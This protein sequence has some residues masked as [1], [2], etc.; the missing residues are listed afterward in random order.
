VTEVIRQ[1]WPEA[2]ITGVDSS[3]AMLARAR[4]ADSTVDWRLGD[5]LEWRPDE[6]VDLV[7]SNAALHWLDGD[8]AL[9]PRLGGGWRGGC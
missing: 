2:R 6:P 4:A 9:F 7:Y 8:A 5:L 1:R 3:A